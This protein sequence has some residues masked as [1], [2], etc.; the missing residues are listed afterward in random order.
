VLNKPLGDDPRHHL[1]GVMLPLA[2]IEAQR[3]RA[4]ARKGFTRAEG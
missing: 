2:A 1:G 4:P 3:E